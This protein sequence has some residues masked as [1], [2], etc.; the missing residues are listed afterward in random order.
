MRW[1]ET[2]A[3][4]PLRNHRPALQRCAT[5][6]AAFRPR[7]SVSVSQKT[8]HHMQT[9]PMM[10]RFRCLDVPSLSPHKLPFNQATLTNHQVPPLLLSSGVTNISFS[11]AVADGQIYLLYIQGGVNFPLDGIRYLE[12]E[13][14]YT[15]PLP[16]GRVCDVFATVRVCI[17]YA[18]ALSI[19][20]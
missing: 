1:T 10:S 16:A 3:Y 6:R 7:D 18:H 15:I 9:S 2:A 19:G 11:D 5:C 4:Y 13:Q 8:Y 14:R 17:S 20:T 12:H